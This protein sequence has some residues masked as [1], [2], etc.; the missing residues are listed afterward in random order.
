MSE[1]VPAVRRGVVAL[2]DGKSLKDAAKEALEPRSDA[3]IAADTASIPRKPVPAQ[4]EITEDLVAA[5]GRVAEV[6]GTVQ[7]AE[8]RMLTESEV[9]ALFE[10]RAVVKAVSDALKDREESIKE[11]VRTHMD[12]VAEASGEVTDETLRDASGHYVLASKGNPE[13]IA[14]P[15]TAKD[16]SREYREGRIEIDG[17][18]LEE[19]EKNGEIDREDY[20]SMTRE[21][22]VF[23]EAKAQQA[24]MKKP[25]RM[26]IIRR[27][28]KRGLA[29]TSLFVRNR[30]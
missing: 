13:R 22:R 10:E 25:E 7:P 23:D 26:E 8:H 30:K 15:G 20:L 4:V 1:L 12:L 18:Q 11:Y 5:L 19:M 14:V 17:Y 24:I 3:E 16:W 28:T 2:R 29:G 27:I 9:Q 6:F 21:V